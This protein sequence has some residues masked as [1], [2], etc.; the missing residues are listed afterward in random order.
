MG[1][2]GFI[3]PAIYR[4]LLELGNDNELAI[5]EIEMI[6]IRDALMPFGFKCSH[7]RVGVSNTTAKPFC[8]DCYARLEQVKGPILKGKVILEPGVYNE[9][10]TFLDELKAKQKEAIKELV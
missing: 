6:L 3:P 10:P 9:L 7:K 8:K 5:K 2:S 4:K 1:I